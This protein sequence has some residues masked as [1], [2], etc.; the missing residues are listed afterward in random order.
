MSLGQGS[1]QSP[2][3][4]SRSARKVQ[5]IEEVTHDKSTRLHKN[6]IYNRY[7]TD[8][9]DIRTG[10]DKTFR[11]TYW[12]M[13]K[14]YEVIDTG[15]LQQAKEAREMS[16]EFISKNEADYSPRLKAFLQAHPDVGSIRAVSTEAL[17]ASPDKSGTKGSPTIGRNV[18]AST[19]LCPGHRDSAR[20]ARAIS[21]WLPGNVHSP[22][23]SCH[24]S[25]GV[26]TRGRDHDWDADVVRT[27]G[28]STMWQSKTGGARRDLPGT[29]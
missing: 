24:S 20:C 23:H 6:F 3:R 8:P 19:V 16:V 27:R 25:Y 2:S 28:N 26:A 22:T 12:Y 4:C 13:K 21:A 10:S 15:G 9:I 5:E 11:R 14:L 17:A 29:V 1:C 18:A 7:R